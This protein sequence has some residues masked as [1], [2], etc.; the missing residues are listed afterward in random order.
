M[1]KKT[2]LMLKRAFFLLVIL[3]AIAYLFVP[4]IVVNFMDDVSVT[5]TEEFYSPPELNR[6]VEVIEIIGDEDLQTTKAEEQETIYINEEEA[7]QTADSSLEETPGKEPEQKGLS[8]QEN[9]D[10]E[11]ARHKRMQP[12]VDK[13]IEN[14]KST[15]WYK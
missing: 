3:A 12:S 2:S 11:E 4:N 7:T 14:I 1:R 15:D 10:R 6:E 9:A 8:H 13:F 5:V